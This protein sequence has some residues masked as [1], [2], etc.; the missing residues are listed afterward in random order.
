MF[1]DEQIWPL[2][3]EE[4]LWVFDKLILSRRLGHVCG[5]ACVPVP[6]PD[7]YVVRPCVNLSGMSLGASIEW[8]EDSTEHLPAGYFWQE[9]FHGRHLSLDYRYGSLIRCTEGFK[10][11]GELARFSRWVQTADRPGVPPFVLD[12]LSQY[13]RGNVEMIG[14]KI[15]EV[16]LRGNSDFD[17]GATEC[18][19]IWKN[20]PTPAPSSEHVFVEN[21]DRDRVGFWKKYPKDEDSA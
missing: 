1:Y 6:K 9:V 3:K 20:D 21:R 2:A 8:I 13:E 19:P 10:P 16:H 4:H 11:D 17:D 12:V 5:P 7:Y 18:V 14:G 15:I